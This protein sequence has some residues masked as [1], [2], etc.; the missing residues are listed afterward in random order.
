M[1]FKILN[2]L[3]NAN[4]LEYLISEIKFL[5]KSKKIDFHVNFDQFKTILLK[6]TNL[7][8]QDFDRKRAEKEKYMIDKIR[9]S[10]RLKRC[11]IFDDSDLLP[12]KSIQMYENRNS[13]KIYNREFNE[14]KR[15]TENIEK[16]SLDILKAVDL[17]MQSKW[18]PGSFDEIQNEPDEEELE[19]ELIQSRLK[20]LTNEELTNV[21]NI[22][23]S[24]ADDTVI[25]ILI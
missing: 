20:P 3:L 4:E 9:Y 13:S 16:P 14:I 23:S 25:Y 6:E 8:A 5:R 18:V 24:P 15:I 2:T 21:Q 10:E 19:D 11:G 12:T 7:S 1:F 17:K 22:L